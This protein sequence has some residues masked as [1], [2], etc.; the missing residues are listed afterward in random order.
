MMVWACV[1]VW[2]DKGNDTDCLNRSPCSANCL[3]GLGSLSY[4]L[5]L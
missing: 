3:L 1:G 5:F 2:S 4:F